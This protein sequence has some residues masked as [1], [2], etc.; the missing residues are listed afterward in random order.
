[1]LMFLLI[2]MFLNNGK[3]SLA[4]MNG[5]RMKKISKAVNVRTSL[6]DSTRTWSYSLKATKNMMDVTFSKQWIHFRLSDRWPPT[7][8]ILEKRREKKK[9]KYKYQ[10]PMY[11]IEMKTYLNCKTTL[12]N[13]FVIT[14]ELI[15]LLCLCIFMRIIP[16]FN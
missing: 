11:Y 10:R 15:F 7:S 6:S 12:H 14:E 3:W 1:M 4:A 8:T 16:R 13:S 5:D 9:K 2:K